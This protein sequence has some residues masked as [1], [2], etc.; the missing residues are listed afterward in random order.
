MTCRSRA[1]RRFSVGDTGGTSNGNISSLNLTPADHTAVDTVCGAMPC[2]V[3]VVSGRPMTITDQLSEIDGLVASWLPGT[4][5]EGVADALFG[6]VPFRGQLPQSWPRSLSQ[7]PIN[8]GD[9]PYD[10]LFP[11]GWGLRTTSAL[12]DAQ[13]ALGELSGGAAGGHLTALVHN[14]KDWNADGSA[15]Q[16]DAVLSA[17]R[18]VAGELGGTTF[19]QKQAVINVAR[20]VAQ[21]AIVAAGGPDATTSPLIADADNALLTGKPATAA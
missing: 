10:P 18:T 9:N 11:F 2:V 19:A 15:A 21:S 16:P 8:V 5:G 13:T 1:R 7:E 6:D 12:A 3:L 17:L 4:E 20:D 14:H